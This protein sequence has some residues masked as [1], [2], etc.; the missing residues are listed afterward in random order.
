[1]HSGLI[2]TMVNLL[3]KGFLLSKDTLNPTR[4]FVYFS[5]LDHAAV[6]FMNGIFNECSFSLVLF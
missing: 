6:Y 3:L 5:A 4:R 1:M 2:E